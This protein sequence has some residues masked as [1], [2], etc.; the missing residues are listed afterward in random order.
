MA[1]KHLYLHIGT[2]KTGTTSI[3]TTLRENVDKLK[4]KGILYP[5]FP[6]L[7]KN[8]SGFTY[9]F[10]GDEAI[11]E[12]LKG[13]GAED[14]LSMATINPRFILDIL[15]KQIRESDCDTVII[16]SEVLHSHITTKEEIAQIKKWAEEHFDHV[17]VICYLRKQIDMLTSGF[18]TQIKEGHPSETMLSDLFK[19]YIEHIDAGGD[20]PHYANYRS[21][22]DMWSNF[23]SDIIC[24]EYSRASLKDGDVVK[25]F[26][27]IINPT[28]NE[29]F[30]KITYSEN[31]SLD[32]KVLEFMAIL[33]KFIPTLKEGHLNFDRIKLL[34][35]A[36]QI[37]VETKMQANQKDADTLQY[38]FDKD[39]QYISEKYFNGK[40]IFQNSSTINSTYKNG[41]NLEDAAMI[42]NKFF[43]LA[44]AQIAELEAENLLGQ[45]KE[46]IRSK[47]YQLA[48]N[49]IDRALVNS[50]AR[51][52]IKDLH[53]EIHR[54]IE[55]EKSKKQ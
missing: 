23:F 10:L 18:S 7:Q 36:E 45:A 49:L 9:S 22:L 38:F 24:H 28:L 50:I 2:E 53:K 13:V 40:P 15:N 17:T 14:M 30:I 20:I 16:S 37:P 35:F 32:G 25:D 5:Y 34:E 26:L 31:K 1:Q 46:A 52:E 29:N 47:N 19:G 27:N 42:F 51:P 11:P 4:E 39:N 6:L 21:M 48:R 12:L 8:H 3:Q 44:T 33:N 43:T 41:L 55:E 54:L